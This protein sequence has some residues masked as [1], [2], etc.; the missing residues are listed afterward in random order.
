MQLSNV[1]LIDRQNS[2]KKVK[3]HNFILAPSYVVPWSRKNSVSLIQ[4]EFYMHILIISCGSPSARTCIWYEM[5]YDERGLTY[6][7]CSSIYL[8]DT[9]NF[10]FAIPL[11][12]THDFR[13]HLTIQSPICIGNPLCCSILQNIQI[14]LHH[15]MEVEGTECFANP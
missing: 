11:L 2:L 13:S 5:W 7:F 9:D 10:H 4:N 12:G 1:V 14:L 8:T 15:I 6:T 3:I